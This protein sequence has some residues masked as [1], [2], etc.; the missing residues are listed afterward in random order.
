MKKPRGWA[1]IQKKWEIPFNYKVIKVKRDQS[2]IISLFCVFLT[3]RLV[4]ATNELI[5]DE[6]ATLNYNLIIKFY[7]TNM[8][9]FL[10]QNEKKNLQREFKMIE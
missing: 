10:P 9:L 5:N 2:Q 7:L 8:S 6:E 1:V 3:E 4:V